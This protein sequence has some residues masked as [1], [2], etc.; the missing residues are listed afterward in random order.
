MSRYKGHFSVIVFVCLFI[1]GISG[2][3]TN[4]QSANAKNINQ[5]IDYAIRVFERYSGSQA[6]SE[7]SQISPVLAS[8][9]QTKESAKIKAI[10]QKL[11]KLTDEQQKEFDNAL[12]QLENF[13]NQ[14]PDKP[15][16][17]NTLAI[18]KA[19]AGQFHLYNSYWLIDEIERQQISQRQLQS[20]IHTLCVK[21]NAIKSEKE[22]LQPA[23]YQT[24]IRKTQ[25]AIKFLQYT[26]A[27]TQNQLNEIEKAISKLKSKLASAIKQRN[28][29]DIE[30]G[31]LSRKM[32][33]ADAQK[34]LELQKKINALEGKRFEI[35]TTIQ[36]LRTGPYTLNRP[37]EIGFLKEHQ[38][39]K[40]IGGIEQLKQEQ[41]RL[42]VRLSKI[43]DAIKL[44]REY[45]KNINSQMKIATGKAALVAKQLD[46]LTA[47]L[48]KQ[49][50]KLDE[51]VSTHQKLYQKADNELSQAVKLLKSAQADAKKYISA[52]KQAA[53]NVSGAGRTDNFLQEASKT[54]NLI[55]SIDNV[56]VDALL[57]K[58]NLIANNAIYIKSIANT[59]KY[60]EE[61]TAAPEMLEKLAKQANSQIAKLNKDKTSLV[62]Q[63]IKISQSAAKSAR[64]DM[65][66]IIKTQFAITLYQAASI[67]PERASEY[68]QQAKDILNE[69]IS[70]KGNA[71]QSTLIAAKELAEQL[72]T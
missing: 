63:A 10:Q 53:S 55:F 49:L 50:S 17:A 54:Q 22:M 34:A 33:K 64:G 30:I 71:N 69:I 3:G 68:I 23:V 14:T 52:I 43:D 15:A 21:I 57:L 67:A 27:Q 42:K 62:E 9:P 1:S 28:A 36:K 26:K 65:D 46:G 38:T 25:S 5:A 44:Q 72:G 8:L 70:K 37:I 35:S 7:K 31:K 47:K 6:I 45:L 40:T 16:N 19:L 66:A 29:I 13:I 61:I 59:L 20:Q 39:L 12:K 60:S 18:A 56:L 4:N 58:A 2:C 51:Y 41:K 11:K 32:D 24:V 48:K